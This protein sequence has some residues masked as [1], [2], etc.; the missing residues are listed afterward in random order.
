VPDVAF[1][2]DVYPATLLHFQGGWLGGGNGTSQAAPIFA[3]MVL[4]LNE[5]A[6]SAGR[7]R[8]GFA[9]PLLYHLGRTAPD[10]FHDV[11]RGDN[12][13][14]DNEQRFDVDCCFAGEGY[15]LTSGW[16]SLLLDR[17]LVAI[18][19]RTRLIAIGPR[20]RL[21]VHPRR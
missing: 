12:I 19:A 3:A 9:P 16:G 11:V 6:A 10:A 1:L 18:E 14:G 20:A 17:A 5:S 15:D 4:L 8:T 21:P 2:A 13:I 7:P